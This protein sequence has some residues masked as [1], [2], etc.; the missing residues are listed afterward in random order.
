MISKEEILNSLRTGRAELEAALA[1]LSAEQMLRPGTCG[2]EW[3]VKDLMGHIAAWE[4]HLLADYAR[5]FAGQPVREFAG[6]EE[7]DRINAATFARCREAPLAEM[8]AEFARSYRRV[9]AWVEG[10]SEEQLARPYLYG[11]SVGEFIRIDTY[12]HY[13]EHLPHLRELVREAE[14]ANRMQG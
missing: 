9:L 3:S 7:V 4:Q 12:T 2:G 5:L 6:D 14:K 1:G 8:Q 10:A 11:M 13:A